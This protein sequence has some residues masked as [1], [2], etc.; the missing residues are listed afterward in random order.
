MCVHFNITFAP[1]GATAKA[2]RAR[3][4]SWENALMLQAALL[5]NSTR[6]WAEAV[7]LISDSG[8]T[9]YKFLIERPTE[10]NAKLAA[11]ILTHIQELMND[12]NE[13]LNEYH[14][15]KETLAVEGV[16]RNSA[17][18]NE[19]E[20]M[21]REILQSSLEKRYAQSHMRAPI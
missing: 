20:S 16:G 15:S 14:F 4:R 19:N 17:K 5:D 13:N 1:P 7:G 11:R 18:E 2:I 8:A 3:G 21:R 9:L 6:S 10:K 12:A